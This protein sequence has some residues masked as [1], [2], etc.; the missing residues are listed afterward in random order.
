MRSDAGTPF[1]V[2]QA[3][4]QSSAGHVVTVVVSFA[5]FEARLGHAYCVPRYPGIAFRRSVFGPYCKKLQ[6]KL[7]SAR[8]QPPPRPFGVA[9]DAADNQGRTAARQRRA[10]LR[11][12]RCASLST[13]GASKHCCTLQAALPSFSLSSATGH[14]SFTAPGEPVMPGLAPGRRDTSF[15]GMAF[16]GASPSRLHIPAGEANPHTPMRAAKPPNLT[17]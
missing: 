16:E 9:A 1:I 17:P 10:C 11:K 7:Q 14:H 13:S 4:S 5:P 12:K 3:C 15:S 6:C 2:S 8:H